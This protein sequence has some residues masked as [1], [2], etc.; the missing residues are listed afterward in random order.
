MEDPVR[1]EIPA[2]HQKPARRRLADKRVNKTEKER[3]RPS[4]LTEDHAGKLAAHLTE[5]DRQ[6][7]LDCYE[8]HVLTTD[9][10]KRLHFKGLRTATVRLQLLYDLRV[11]DRFRPTA[12][13][14]EGFAP[15]HW[16]LDE[17]GALIVADHKG[18]DR[19]Q[20]H[21]THHEALRI[22]TSHN[23]SH[24]V[25]ANQFF[26][27]LAVEANQAGGALAEWYGVRTLAHLFAGH[28]IPD[29][30]GVLAMPNR[31]PLHLLL[32]L[33]R[34]T[35]PPQVLRA[36]AKRYSD[37]LPHSSLREHKPVVILAVP[38]VRRSQTATTAVSHT[39]APIVVTVWNT[40]T[41]RS[42][43]ATVTTVAAEAYSDSHHEKDA[44]L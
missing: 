34:G 17:A 23:L 30:W 25:E 35:E 41:A 29:G 12:K 28:V 5:R 31:P 38:S 3:T 15:Y 37:A 19:S 8:H 7:A 11:L 36:K 6:I 13:R 42:V 21:Y 39:S 43:L 22:A 14:G 1:R 26:T 44:N 20:L 4:R 18:I 32:E 24:H 40:A 16:I 33:D 27:R 10:L 2:N 9:Q